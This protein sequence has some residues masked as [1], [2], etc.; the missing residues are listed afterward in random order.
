MILDLM[1]HW[2]VDRR[3]SFLIGDKEIDMQAAHAAGI[4]GKLFP[5]GD[6]AEFVEKCLQPRGTRSVN[7]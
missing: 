6:L 1:Q 3:R 7:E 4:D 5:G 2:P